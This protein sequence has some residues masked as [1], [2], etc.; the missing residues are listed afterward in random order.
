MPYFK[1]N[2][3]T[4]LF[5][6][7]WGSGKPIIFLHAW[8]MS[9]AEWGC[10]MLYF[11]D[12]GM[13]CIAYDQRG[14][15]RSDDPGAGYDVDTLADDLA[16]LIEHLDLHD[17]I[18]I[19]HSVGG[20]EIIRYLSR[21]GAARIARVVLVAAYAPFLLKTA[22]NPDGIEPVLFA[23]MRATWSKD[24]P[25]W[26]VDSADGFYL[27]KSLGTSPE[28]I[29]WTFNLML[30]TSMKAVIEINRTITETDFRSEMGAINVPAIVIHGDADQ[31]VPVT[32]G[33]MAAQLIPNC[34]YREYAGAPHGL[35]FTHMERF[36]ADI[37][38]FIND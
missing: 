11:N 2:D 29:R 25:K 1:T 23:N 15:G 17:V 12:Q 38:N 4:Q 3:Q 21:H 5:Y 19:G 24:F 30:Q 22:D 37:F 32:F 9:S 7:D 26:L 31:S 33:R 36:N 35:F 34:R 20:S 18:L 28:I 6:Q 27:P 10:H 13:R 8:A 14:H 16:V